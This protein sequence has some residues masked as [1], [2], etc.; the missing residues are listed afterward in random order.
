MRKTMGI[1]IIMLFTIMLCASSVQAK[2]SAEEAARLGKDLTPMG[3]EM[4]GNADGTIPPWTGGITQPPANYKPGDHHPDP[5]ADDKVLFKITKANMAKYADKLTEGHKALLAADE[6]YYLNVYPTRRSA[7]APQRIYDATKKNALTATLTPDGNGINAAVGIPFPIPKNGLEAIW[8]HLVHYRGNYVERNFVF[9]PVTRG[10]SYN[11]GRE[12]TKVRWQY[13]LPGMTIEKMNN[14]IL[15]FKQY[16]TAPPRVAG[17]LLIVHDTLDQSREPRR[18]WTYNPGQRRVR[19]APQVAFDT[20]GTGSDGLRTIDDYEMYNG[21]PE[22]YTWKLVGKKEMYIPYNCYKLHSGKLKYKDIIRPQHYN[23]ELLR[24]ELH[25]VWVVEANLKKG[26]RHIYKKRVFYLD[27][28]SWG[29]V[30]TDKYDNHDKLWRFAEAFIINYY[31]VPCTWS[32]SEVHYDLPSGRY[33]FYFL[34]NEEKTTYDFSKVF[35][36]EEF[37]ISSLRR[38]GRR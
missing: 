3:G 29:V 12:N 10:G 27:E 1:A 14:V 17:R 2:V 25:R 9:A 18:A 13:S 11:L 30:A 33:L 21:S 22:R 34:D 6:N 7:S 28:D 23:P 32:T 4:A 16:L 38:S 24:Y 35:P 36:I 8:N 37:S 26:T 19:R 31:D 5:F 20:P 15:Y